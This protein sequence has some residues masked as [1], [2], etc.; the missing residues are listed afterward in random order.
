ME[1]KVRFIDY[2]GQYG[3]IRDDILSIVDA[4]LSAG[5]VMLRQQ[6]TERY[7]IVLVDSRTGLNE[8]SDLTTGLLPDGIVT[9]GGLHKQN[10][11][12]LKIA[13]HGARTTIS[14]TIPVLAVA[15]PVGSAEW[16]LTLKLLRQMHAELDVQLPPIC[17]PYDADVS[18]H[19]EPRIGPV[20]QDTYGFSVPDDKRP[21]AD[22]DASIEHFRPRSRP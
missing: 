11:E 10:F 9:L 1:W 19:P 16:T 12:G 6:L 14:D 13:I 15:S 20:F 18:L 3:K 7:D 4:T 22:L 21:S 5:D 17:V 8:T 2:P